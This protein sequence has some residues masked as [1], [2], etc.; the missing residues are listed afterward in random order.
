MYLKQNK[1][2]GR[3]HLLIAHGYK[4]KETKKTRTKTIK[5]IGYLDELEKEFNDPISHFKSVVNEMNEKE[6]YDNP[7]CV[8]MFDR[9]ETLTS[10]SSK[11]KNLGYAVLSKIYYKLG[12]DIF[13]YNHSRNIKADFNVNSIMKTEIFSRL[14]FPASKKKTYENKDIFFENTEYELIDVYRCLSHV[15]KLSNVVQKHLHLK[16]KEHYGRKTDLVYYDV[17][18]YYFEIDE[19][20]ELRKKGVSKEHRPDPIIQMGLFMDTAGVPISYRLFAGNT[21]DCETL[22]PYLT[23][24]KRDFDDIRRVIVVADKGLNTSPN[25]VSNTLQG[26]GYVFS[27]KVRGA[28]GELQ[29]Y[30]LDNNGYTWLNDDYKIKSRLFPR[31]VYVTDTNGKQKQVRLDEKQVVFYSKAYDKKAKADREVAVIKARDLVCNPSKYKKATSYGA[32]KYVKNLEYDPKTGEI[33][34]SKK[35][36]IFDEQKLKE[37]EKWDGY[38]A[39]VTSELDKTDNEIIEIYRGLWKIEESFKVTK[40]DLEARPVYLSRQDRI[41]AHFLICFIA[42]VIGRIL[43][44]LLDNNYSITQLADSLCRTS[45]SPLEENWYLFDYTDEIILD[46]KEKLGIDLTYKYLRLGEIKII[47]ANTKKP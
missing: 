25:I 2:N 24:V 10:M 13:F 42:L 36:P 20:D 17:T 14:L 38:Y 27:Q 5:T 31:I 26:D 44:N 37:E 43:E 45:C 47:L 18:N 11:R 12:L 21:N 33:L 35:Q 46:I 3:V 29:E 15:S 32:A 30:V 22:Y 4:D 6:K 39:I 9:K 40:N 34:V 7:P 8:I 23:Q 41:E 1:V 19:Q 16:I 28:N